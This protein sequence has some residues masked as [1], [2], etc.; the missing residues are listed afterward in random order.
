[1]EW[2]YPWGII[3]RKQLARVPVEQGQFSVNEALGIARQMLFD[4]PQSLLGM[5][6]REN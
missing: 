5:K 2:T 6:P 3:V 4:A 1:M